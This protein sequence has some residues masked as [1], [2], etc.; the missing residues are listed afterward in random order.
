M[1]SKVRGKQKQQA[2]RRAQTPPRPPRAP[3]HPA[4]ADPNLGG[5]SPAA[6]HEGGRTLAADLRTATLLAQSRAAHGA[7]MAVVMRHFLAPLLRVY[8]VM[9][10]ISA[11]VRAQA[12]AALSP[13]C[14]AGC[15]AC[16]RLYVEVGP[17]EAF[18]IAAYVT[19]ACAPAGV[20]RERVLARLQ[21]EVTRFVQSGG[22]QGALRLCAFLRPDGHCGIYPARPA[23][24]RAY[25]SNS[26]AVCERHF[27]QVALDKPSPPSIVRTADHG[28]AAQLMLAETLAT[29]GA[30]LPPGEAPPLYEMQSMVLRILETPNALV[31][32]LHGEDIFQGC[33]RH[34]PEPQL[35]AARERL[36]QLHVPAPPCPR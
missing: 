35:R 6:V 27:G 15:F 11:A 18:G 8:Q 19:Q 34:S 20:P 36:L 21:D 24:C 16:C 32:Y 5:W 1:T 25:Y 30:P 3:A 12:R 33:A 26:R 9:D 28:I 31:R 10:T 4:A 2:R 13:A 17:W 14:S 29:A 23:A 7:P 22:D